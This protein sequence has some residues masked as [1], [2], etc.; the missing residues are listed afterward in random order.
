[1]RLIVLRNIF[2]WLLTFSVMVF[3]SACSGGGGDPGT[4]PFGGGTSKSATVV[5]SLSN[6]T[7]TSTAPVT[8]SATVKTASGS[9]VANALVTFTVKGTLSVLSAKPGLAGSVNVSELTDSNGIAQASLSPA[10]GSAVG[11]EYVEATVT[12]DK[13]SISSTANFQVSASPAAN[14]VLAIS[15]NLV[16]A[17]ERATLTATVTSR[18]GLPLVNSVVTFT[19]ESGP[20][21][22]GATSALTDASG[23]AKVYLSPAGSSAGAGVVSAK[24][25]T[26]T[27][28]V[29]A[30]VNYQ[31]V[32][33]A[34]ANISLSL[35]NTTVTAGGKPVTVTVTVTS[36]TE[37]ISNAK[38]LFSVAA[39]LGKLSASS[40]LTNGAGQ[41]TVTLSPAGAIVS[42][43]DTVTAE[44]TTNGV[45]IQAS[46]NFQLIATS[47]V[48]TSLVVSPGEAASSPLSAYGQSILNVKM[49]GVSDTAPATV[50]FTSACVS[51]NKAVISPA[52]VTTTTGVF[53]V[54]YVD[55]GCGA[56]RGSDTVTASAG[57]AQIQAPIYL[58]SPKVNSI[59]FISASPEIIY[60]RG[61]GLD[62][63]STVTFQVNDTAGNPLPGQ[64][65]VLSLTTFAG[66]LTLDGVGTSVTKTTDANGQVS[67]IV[68]SGTVPTPIRVSATLASGSGTVS[69][70][71]SQLAVAVGLPSQLNF[72]MSQGTFNIEAFDYDGIKNTYT[73][74]AADRS[75]NP[76]PDGTTI[77]FWAEG[78]QVE[79]SAQTKKTNGISSATVNF[80]S[81]SPRPADGRVTVVAYVIGEE[82]FV[83]LNGNNI[84]D[85]GEP[86]QDLGDVLKDMHYDNVF[87]PVAND[88][89]EYVSLD[90]VVNSK[91][92]DP[93]NFAS[94]T[95]KFEMSAYTPSKV[96]SCDGVW[97]S[98]AYVRR[99]VETIF[100][101][102]QPSL[103]FVSKSGGASDSGLA[104]SCVKG[105]Y[106]RGWDVTTGAIRNPATPFPLS[107]NFNWYTGGT[108]DSPV[109]SGSVTVYVQDSNTVR[110]NPMP[111]GTK[112]EA[113]GVFVDI[114]ST[115]GTPV[116]NTTEPSIFSVAFK[117]QTG[118]TSGTIVLKTTTPLGLVLQQAVNVIAG[119]KPSSCAL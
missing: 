97:S 79:A 94:T 27:G 25:A 21:S 63:V 65:I 107:S 36:G 75:G 47:A 68:N 105:S 6:T 62:D 66:G 99:A 101:K 42:G 118:H 86:F 29:S 3:F 13:V 17:A 10:S 11:A 117:F 91:V 18:T 46:A 22:L 84:Y 74:Y 44:V 24:V 54:S 12:V 41:A 8:V 85:L 14:I 23:T 71:S 89:D 102:S 56:V 52:S 51:E 33:T 92:C 15:S 82:S 30:S 90:S 39:G 76:L 106:P 20:G 87:T 26:A 96:N 60:L 2:A 69:T 81:Q 53:S 114:V 50:S 59:K 112:V 58:T 67:I 83:D 5:L 72:S 45:T 19:V 109:T 78:G 104:G 40:A 110:W 93:G 103:G 73:I 115:A 95:P 80:V 111:A 77:N 108:V 98:R 119:P 64:S 57:S 37:L 43:A 1:V 32:A 38:V 100:S 113:E 70:V 88:F 28:D 4:S 34:A 16:T 35:S 9:P 116:P 61:S 49:A 7:V 55:K 31:A 48:F